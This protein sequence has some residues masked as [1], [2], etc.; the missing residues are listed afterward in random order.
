MSVFTV[1]PVINTDCDISLIENDNSL[2]W[3]GTCDHVQ[4][5]CKEVLHHPKSKAVLPL[6]ARPAYGLCLLSH[7]VLISFGYSQRLFFLI[8]YVL[9][10]A[11]CDRWV[12]VPICRMQDC[13]KIYPCFSHQ[14]AKMSTVTSQHKDPQK[15]KIKALGIIPCKCRPVWEAVCRD[16]SV[17]LCGVLCVGEHDTTLL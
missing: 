2:N 10:L 12:L 14:T 9:R 15:Y 4:L 7:T 13:R 16:R 11:T 1:M 8:N 17:S 6:Y 5:W 3:G